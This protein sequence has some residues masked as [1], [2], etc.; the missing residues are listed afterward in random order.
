[1]SSRFDFGYVGRTIRRR[2]HLFI[3][4]CAL[5]AAAGIAI[6]MSMPAIYTA[7]AKILVESQQI[8]DSLVK[9]TIT[10]LASERLQVIQQRVLT[11]DNLL[12]LVDKFALF[13][14]RKNLTRS[15][16]VDLMRGR[17]VFQPLDLQANANKRKD[18]VITAFAIE[19]NYENP[20]VV[21]RVANDLVTFILEEDAKARTGRASDTTK[22]LQREVDRLSAELS[23]V[24]EGLSNFKLQNT[25]TLPEKLAFNM[26]LLDKAERNINS[27]QND[28][29]SNDEQQRLMKL[30]A[31]IKSTPA[32]APTQDALSELRKKL[33]EAQSFYALRKTQLADSHPEMRALRGAIAALQNE[34]DAAQKIPVDPQPVVATQDADQRLYIEKL[35]TLAQQRK[36]TENQLAKITQ[37]VEALRAIVIKTPETGS[38]L[39]VLERKADS[40]QRSYDDMSA[41]FAQARLGERMEQDQQAERFQVI[42]QPVLPQSPTKPKRVPLILAAIAASVLAGAITSGGAEFLDGTL[43]RSSDIVKQLKQNP[44][45]VIP[46]I[47]TKS[48][49]RL[50]WL[51]WIAIALF[52]I[53]TVIA[54]LMVIN[55]FYRPLDE[56]FYKIL[57]FLHVSF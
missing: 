56:L 12:S 24:Q 41:K 57:Q 51:K 11:R 10:D 49:R 27:L 48:E 37:D 40:L 53:V 36:A 54:A 29:L 25:D 55:Q 28:L 38:V 43:R 34:L 19:F 31:S 14:D 8:P 33:A 26:S 3:I 17:I 7:D 35:E 20:G 15:D 39:S 42:E 9:S 1:M 4:P 18:T 30:E 2:F 16:V 50:K 6:V 21:V 52:W 32:G 22:F 5:I 23:S 47:P 46:Y 44:I 13:E 45:V